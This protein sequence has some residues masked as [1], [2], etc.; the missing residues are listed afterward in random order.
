MEKGASL[1]RDGERGGAL[2]SRRCNSTVGLLLFLALAEAAFAASD[3]QPERT[4]NHGRVPF[5]FVTQ[6]GD[7]FGYSVAA[8]GSDRFVVG[9]PWRE[10]YDGVALQVV[11]NVG[12]VRIYSATGTRIAIVPNPIVEAGAG[13][14]Y[15]V[16]GGVSSTRFAVGAPFHDFSQ[17]NDT[18]RVYIYDQDGGQVHNFVNPE[19]AEDDR[20][21]S[22]LAGLGSNLV[23]IGAP[24]DDAGATGSGRV[25]IYH[26]IITFTRL[27]TVSNPAP[28]NGDRFGSALALVGTDRLVIGAEQDDTTAGNAGQVYLCDLD[29]N[30]IKGIGPPSPSGGDYFGR[31]VAGV[32]TD[33]FVVGAPESDVQT[34]SAGGKTQTVQDAGRV[35]LFDHDGNLLR[36]ITNPDPQLEGDFGFALARVGDRRFLVGAPSKNVG[37]V[38][39]AGVAYLYNLDG[40]L[41]ATIENPEPGVGDRF[42]HAL[43]GLGEDRFVIS[44]PDNDTN[45]DDAGSVYIYHAPILEHTLGSE[46]PKPEN[47]NLNLLPATGPEVQPAGAA[48]W[49]QPTKKLYAVQAGSVIL[50]WKQDADAQNPQPTMNVQALNVWPNSDSAYQ[51]HVIGTPAVDLTGGGAYQSVQLMAQDGTVGTDANDVK[52]GKR[53]SATGTGRSLLLLST[54]LPEAAPIFFQVVKSIAWNDPAYLHDKVPAPV[55]AEITDRFGY[56]NASCGGPFVYWPNSFYCADANFYDRSQR[57]GPIIPVNTDQP[58]E[59]DDM[60]LIYYQQSTKLKDGDGANVN[61]PLCWPWKAVR[62]DV[63]WPT[64]PEKIIIASLQGSREIDPVLFKDWDVY[65]QNDPGL[66]GFNPN[67]EH[68]LRRPYGAGEAIFALR[69]DLGTPTTS[70]PFVLMKYLGGPSQDRGQMKVF[71]VVAEEDPYFFDYPGT[72]GTLV[73]PPFPLSTLQLCP[74][75]KGVSGPY[76]RDRKMSFWA[77]AAGDD[78]GLA[79]IVMRFFYPVQPGFFFPEANPPALGTCVPWLDVRAGTPGEPIDIDY[80][81]TWPPAPEL[82]VQETLVKPKFGLPDISSQTSVEIL[83]QQAEAQGTGSSV[84]LIDPT[85][86]RQVSLTRIP[87][88]VVTVTEGGQVFFPTLPPAL[89]NRLRYDPLNQLLKFRGEFIEPPAGEY[90]LLLNVIT[91]REKAILLTLSSDATFQNAITTLAAQA[92]TVITVSSDATVFDSLALT[93]GFA[94]GTG[95]VTLAFGNNPELSPPAEPV[96]LQIIKVLCPVYRG[97]I[98]VIA[99]ANPFDEKLTLRHSG[100]FAGQTDDFVFEWRT[101]PPVDG[102]PADQP[103]DRWTTFTPRPPS[104]Q[105]AVDITIEGPGLQTLSDNYFMCRYKRAS[106]SGP[107]GDDWSE[108]TAPMLAEGWIKRVLRGINPFEQRIQAYRDNQVNTIVSMISQAGARHV[109]N[110]PL[111]LA[112]AEKF[113]LIEIYETVLQRGLSL[114]ID[115]TPP[116]NY[117]PANDALLLVAGRLADLYMLLGNEAYADAADPTIGFGT[118]HGVFGVAAPSIHCFMNQTASLLEEELALLRGRDDKLLPGVQRYPF[119]N[120]LVWN[121]TS[122]ITGGEVAYAL[123]YNVR[124]VDGDVAGSINEA[125]AR[126]L[127]PQGHGDAW[128]H[129]LTAIKNYYRLL[130][131]PNFTWAPRIEAVLVGGVPVSVDY[132]DERKFAQSAA[133]RAR[134]GAEIV[135]LTYRSYYVEDPQGQYQGYQDKDANRAWG[136]SEWGSR[137]GQGALFDWVVASAILPPV[138]PNPDH[139]GIQKVDRTTVGELRDIAAAFQEIQMQVDNADVGLNPL[140]LAKNVVPFDID[141]AQVTSG[142]THFEQVYDRAVKALNNA[143][144]TFNNANN[145]T[146]ALRQ[147]ADEVADFQ[148]AVLERE[149]DFNSRLIEVFGYPY[150]DDIGP[151]G[152]YP[153]GYDGPDVYHYEYVDPSELLGVAPPPTQTVTV[154][155]KEFEVGDGGELEEKSKEIQ[156]HVAGNGFGLIKPDTWKGQRR[157][158]GEIQ[159]ARSDFFQAR[160]RLQRALVEYDNLLFRIEDEAR[161]LRAQYDLNAEE[162]QLLDAA[163]NTQLSLTDQINKQRELQAWLNFGARTTDRVI[164]ALATAITGFPPKFEEPARGAVK[165]GGALIAGIL[166]AGAVVSQGTEN[167]RLRSKE[168]AELLTNIDLTTLR[169]EFAVRQQVAQ[170]EQLIREEAGLRLELFAV[171]ESL[172]QAAGRYLA[173]LARAQRLLEDRLRFRQ[174]TAEKVQ[175][176]R[177]KDM[178]FRI[179]RNDALQKFRAQFDLAARYVFLAARAYD[180]ETNLRKGDSRG[181]GEEF[182]TQIVRARAL[183]IIQNGLPQTGTGRGDAGLA[184]PMARMFQNWDLVLKGQLGFNN[185]QTET[186]RFSLRSELFRIQA[187][188]KGNVVWRETLA[189]HVVENLL[190]LPEF[191]RYCIPFTPQLPVEPAIVIPFSTTINFALNFF[192]WPAGG[193]DNDY[194]STH[195]A[196]KIRTVGVWFAN[197]NS[198][199]GGMINTPRVYLIPVGNDVLRSPT[200]PAGQIRE[201][202]ILDQALPVPFPLSGG[203]LTE[204]RWIPANDTLLGQ[205]G[206]LR[207]YARFRAYHDSGNFNPAETI[208]DSRL[209]GRSVWNTRWLLIIPAGTLHSDRTE[210]LQRFIHGALLPNGTRDGNGVADIKV[211]FQTYAY[212]GN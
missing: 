10:Q 206:E 171:Q 155:V 63:S 182:M 203:A 48:Y 196:T 126:I 15:S 13:F 136:L 11:T 69:D 34:T 164:E 109:G 190:D 158:P 94:T 121:F 142:K 177:Y 138:D 31:A 75:S 76:W 195:F 194:D 50:R 83:Y 68:A 51:L 204:P 1:G 43:T 139:K 153:T 99:S 166:E 65:F 81:I 45:V 160:V 191:Q 64:N 133:A 60:V 173:A 98:K 134:T 49:H 176:Y 145:S 123:N 24:L 33:W 135:N 37:N 16:A 96:A 79:R 180:F 198:L 127:Y 77:R 210:G 66:A 67:D 53:F 18:G 23:A 78:G 154:T 12:E 27:A 119:Y 187:G 100:D 89:R 184:D 55:G 178:A 131:N 141:P 36:T 92:A 112:A 159:I 41:L 19:R 107:C 29:G 151:T 3:L 30:V 163:K 174:Q 149:A 185:P 87:S 117:P 186:G 56:H 179:F 129:Y 120:R 128:G 116:V 200:S 14:G 80:T 110:V 157:A 169:N 90:Y 183:G 54:G 205:L 104:G 46:I 208:S 144:A 86:E 5:D 58:T 192:G 57:T 212:A 70:Q 28:A 85:R 148:K 175:A 209:I 207:R 199:G 74:P 32:G 211:F 193:G 156:F 108:W 72:A 52:I 147:Q 44:A 124:D 167:E 181:P 189:R 168:Q 113:G 111:N 62:Y 202:K 20:F 59:T 42:G 130:R 197:Y 17:F 4:I 162:L 170:L 71:K 22:V 88:D 165:A 118:S 25:Y 103:P 35:F 172:Q 8:L 73:Q 40:D 146:Q 84:K 61:S 7:Q 38:T 91:D 161:L 137:A 6:P 93:A 2:A 152:A 132:L 9:L 97:E 21:G 201:W 140:G 115:G 143:I 102:L 101:L 125:D 122:D 105:G 82:R 95:Y 106:A 188:A 26:Q 114:S 39:G 150:A 47:V